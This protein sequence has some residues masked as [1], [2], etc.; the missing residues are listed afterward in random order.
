M[1][2]DYCV[3]CLSADDRLANEQLHALM[4]GVVR[5]DRIQSQRL[6]A[7]VTPLL[8]AFYEGQAQ[9]GRIS[10]DQTS[11]LVQQAFKTLYLDQE[12]YDP[13]QPFRAWIIDIAR[14]TLLGN[15]QC[16]ENEAAVDLRTSMT[17]RASDRVPHTR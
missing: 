12:R 2:E 17:R 8:I 9:A 10:R 4:A 1:V 6:F 16:H 11:G 14:S 13:N 3:S 7:T 15:R 5:R